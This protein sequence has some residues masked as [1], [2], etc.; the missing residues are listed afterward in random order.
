MM[1]NL[2]VNPK[3]IKSFGGPKRTA[4]GNTRRAK[5]IPVFYTFPS[6]VYAKICDMVLRNQGQALVAIFI[7]I[8]AALG[9]ATTKGLVSGIKTTLA[10]FSKIAASQGIRGLV[11]YLKV[12]SVCLQ[13][14]ITGHI[15]ESPNEPRVS[16]TRSG[17]PRVFP[18]SIRRKIQSHSAITIRFALSMLSIYRDLSFKGK[19]KL[20]TITDPSTA[21]QGTLSMMIGLIPRFTKLFVTPVQPKGGM[22]LW[23]KG[24]FSYFPISTSS[25]SSGGVWPGSHPYNLLRA[26]RSLT[27]KQVNDLA[28]LCK[29][30]ISEDVKIQHPIDMIREIKA[31]P[32]YGDTADASYISTFIPTGKLGL[33]M[34]AAGKVRVFAMIDP[35][36]QWTL[37]PFHKGIFRIISRHSDIDGTFNQ[38]RPL[39]RA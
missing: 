26:A 15:G 7:R 16:K 8:Y 17:I 25:P 33:K 14:Y 27:D 19:M 6:F 35:W 11:L 9:G 2:G 12:C 39:K 37:Y 13:H 20:S 24:R 36:S 29:L 5:A 31:E 10:N 21:A 30:T 18:L 23:L 38:L 3:I 4:K 34:E 32:S 28:I 22:R 1:N